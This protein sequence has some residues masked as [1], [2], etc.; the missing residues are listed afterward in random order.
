MEIYIYFYVMI[1]AFVFFICLPLLLIRPWERKK[2]THRFKD[3]QGLRNLF[4][5]THAKPYVMHKL[6]TLFDA[7]AMDILRLGEQN[8]FELKFKTF[9]ASLNFKKAVLLSGIC[10]E[11]HITIISDQQDFQVIF[12]APQASVRL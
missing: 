4:G 6:S 3:Y 10:L 1:A 11:I 8:Y 2:L 7:T 5:S 12:L 9:R